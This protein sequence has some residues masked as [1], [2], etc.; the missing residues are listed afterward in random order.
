MANLESKSRS[1]ENSLNT[2]WWKNYG[3]NISPSPTLVIAHFPPAPGKID[4]VDLSYMNNGA[5]LT[6]AETVN[7]Q[8]VN[9]IIGPDGYPS[10]TGFRWDELHSWIYPVAVKLNASEL[11][12]IPYQNLLNPKFLG[13]TPG[14]QA[15]VLSLRTPDPQPAGLLRYLSKL[16]E[17]LD[18]GREPY[19]TE[20]YLCL[21]LPKS[22]DGEFT[23]DISRFSQFIR[24][25][26]LVSGKNNYPRRRGGTNIT[27]HG[28]PF[29]RLS[30]A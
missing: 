4:F 1:P 24:L 15:K 16:Q 12:E 7:G 29:D 20:F 9:F 11:E 3:I 14:M 26:K 30:P 10:Q 28:I 25:N 2:N 18:T 17:S 19:H 6:A 23:P 22:Q 8:S 21:R 5:W 13:L 27:L